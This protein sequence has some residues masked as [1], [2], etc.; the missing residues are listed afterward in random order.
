MSAFTNLKNNPVWLQTVSTLALTLASLASWSGSATAASIL[1]FGP[2]RNNFLTQQAIND[3]GHTITWVDASTFTSLTDFSSYD[4]MYVPHQTALSDLSSLSG[5]NA[6]HDGSGGKSVGNVILTGLHSEHHYQGRN[7]N[8]NV[9][10]WLDDGNSNTLGIFA[11]WNSSGTSDPFSWL[12]GADVTASRVLGSDAISVVDTS[13]AVTF[14]LTDN[15]MS[16]WRNSAHQV[17][18]VNPGSQYASLVD[19]TDVPG[20]ESVVLANA[21]SINPKPVPEPTSA[22]SILAFGAVGAGLMLKRKR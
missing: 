20:F 21:S 14:G 5:N 19:A 13:H 7:F 3:R 11:F 22:L 2:V 10:D 16:N 1:G 18:N 4:F 17:F 6:W 9:F 8:L 15:D 12:P